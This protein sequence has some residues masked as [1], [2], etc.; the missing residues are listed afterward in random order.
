MRVVDDMRTPLAAAGGSA[1]GRGNAVPRGHRLGGGGRAEGPAAKRRGPARGARRRA[2][3]HCFGGRRVAEGEAARAARARRAD[4]G[5]V[6]RAGR[7]CVDAR[8]DDVD[9]RPGRG[10]AVHEP[11]CSSTGSSACARRRSRAGAGLSA[12]AGPS[13][14]AGAGA[15]AAP[16]PAESDR[17]QRRRRCHRPR[18]HRP[19]RRPQTSGR[20]ARWRPAAGELHRPCDLHQPSVPDGR[21]APAPR[22][23]RSAKDRGAAAAPHGR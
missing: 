13:A 8:R 6:R 17:R 19:G 2:G 7:G 11:G 22:V 1:F 5:R 20:A 15:G 21:L 3:A 18:G 10:A 14:G 23:R 4:A 16:K 12:R 9:A